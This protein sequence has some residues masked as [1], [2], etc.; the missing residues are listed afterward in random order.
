MKVLTRDEF[1]Y[2]Q[3]YGTE[4][5]LQLEEKCKETGSYHV[6]FKASISLVSF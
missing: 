1:H 6:T 4:G 2:I 5:R 3:E